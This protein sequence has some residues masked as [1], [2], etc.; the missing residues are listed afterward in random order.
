[1]NKTIPS[2]T[3]LYWNN[4]YLE[5]II[6]ITIVILICKKIMLEILELRQNFEFKPKE[7]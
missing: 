1:M 4:N 6:I 7:I 3:S 5:T 2:K